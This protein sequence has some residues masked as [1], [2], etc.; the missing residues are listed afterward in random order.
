[1]LV[2]FDLFLVSVTVS[3]LLFFYLSIELLLYL[4][5]YSSITDIKYNSP[6]HVS[7]KIEDGD[8]IIQ[9][10]CQIVVGWDFK[11]VLQQLE[12][13]PPDVQLRLKKRPRH[14]KIYGQIYMKPYRLPSKKRS[15]P[16]RFNENLPSPRIELIP[17]Q[18]FPMLM[19]LPEKNNLSDTDSSS[20]SSISIP[21]ESIK[22][23]DKDLRLY[24]SK[25]RAVLQRRNTIC[26]D[27][28]SGIRG[29]IMFLHE[30]NMQR[31]GEGNSL[32]DKAVSFGFG[33]EMSS[34][35]RPNTCIGI[36]NVG[37]TY[38]KYGDL[39]SAL[40]GSLPD[41]KALKVINNEDQLAL[42][43]F[44]NDV[45]DNAIS[46]ANGNV[47]PNQLDTNSKAIKFNTTHDFIG[48]KVN[49]SSLLDSIPYA[50]AVDVHDV[51]E[52]FKNTN[53]N[54]NSLDDKPN[55]CT[56]VTPKLPLKMRTLN[57]TNDTGLVEAINFTLIK[58]Q[59]KTTDINLNVADNGK[60]RNY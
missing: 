36:H 28:A 23:N 40:K 29:N 54:S 5:I 46:T 18:N 39:G 4:F 57:A 13:S 43:S 58:S 56:T 55:E 15:L 26:G 10:N 20:A 35:E 42:K 25:P 30:I 50:D 19:P 21:A 59:H 34:A 45:N 16:Y 17:S 60:Y 11:R 32:R 37:N 9:I 24:L 7:G 22:T 48:N 27:P 44:E 31:N 14:T 53:E 3:Y 6:A 1:M 47:V 51:N 33:L 38:D 2:L 8:E 12:E 52:D 49:G 41:I